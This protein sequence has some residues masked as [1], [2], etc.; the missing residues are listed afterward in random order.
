MSQNKMANGSRDNVDPM[1]GSGTK[2][3]RFLDNQ[4]ESETSNSQNQYMFGK[5]SATYGYK[6][7]GDDKSEAQRIT[8]MNQT[9]IMRD[10]YVDEQVQNWSDGDNTRVRRSHPGVLS[11]HDN[12][13]H[14]T[15]RG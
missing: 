4:W 10:G 2:A 13:E 1:S 6:G 14:Y 9:E 15:F 3:R 12:P 8:N 7:S 11:G 5:N